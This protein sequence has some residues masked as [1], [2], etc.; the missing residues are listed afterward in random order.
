MADR[1]FYEYTE[2]TAPDGDDVLLLQGAL[3]QTVTKALIRRL[4]VELFDSNNVIEVADITARNALTYSV[5]SGATNYFNG[6]IVRVLDNA[7]WTETYICTGN[8]SWELISRYQTLTT[9]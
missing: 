9:D 8:A 6:S 1:Q 3:N 7:G 4:W 5:T 2:N